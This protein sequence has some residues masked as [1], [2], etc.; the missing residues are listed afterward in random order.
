VGVG[1]ALHEDEEDGKGGKDE[2]VAYALETDAPC[3]ATPVMDD[4][5]EEDGE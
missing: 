5:L 3:W 1:G 2:S 4:T